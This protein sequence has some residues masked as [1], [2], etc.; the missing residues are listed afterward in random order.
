ME[1]I[2]IYFNSLISLIVIIDALISFFNMKFTYSL[3]SLTLSQRISNKYKYHLQKDGYIIILLFTTAFITFPISIIYSIIQHGF[4]H[5]AI[6]Q[7]I[8]D[9]SLII[10]IIAAYKTSK[11]PSIMSS[12][13][14]YTIYHI[15]YNIMTIIVL[16]ALLYP[17]IKLF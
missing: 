15:T 1:K 14:N 2:S 11:I 4:N 8:T 12:F 7:L 16:L 5:T 9:I 17:N 6:T 10:I 3:E 13:I